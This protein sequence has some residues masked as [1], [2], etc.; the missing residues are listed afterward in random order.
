[1]L[2]NN[3]KGVCQETRKLA[4]MNG[5]VKVENGRRLQ[6][7]AVSFLTNY[8]THSIYPKPCWSHQLTLWRVSYEVLMAQSGCKRHPFEC[9]T[10]HGWGGTWSFKAL[11]PRRD[12]CGGF[13]PSTAGV[14]GEGASRQPSLRTA[15][16]SRPSSEAS[17]LLLWPHEVGKGGACSTVNR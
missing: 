17:A 15:G 11:S 3:K 9:S 10:L 1:M 14:L 2:K 6:F 5:D 8:S 13:R 7:G 4:E 12:Q 16:G